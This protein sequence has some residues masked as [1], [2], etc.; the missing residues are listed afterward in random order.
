MKKYLKIGVVLLLIISNLFFLD[1]YLQ[2]KADKTYP[3]L[4]TYCNAPRMPSGSVYFV[5]DKENNFSLYEVNT[6]IDQ[7]TWEKME[8]NIYIIK[9]DNINTMI[10]TQE[11]YFYYYV[12]SYSE[13]V[14]KFERISF[15]PMYFKN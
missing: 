15:M 5:F 11:D 8:N 7:G 4:G 3:L 1:L 6:L 13:E 9:S 2:E 12:P 14:I 10:H